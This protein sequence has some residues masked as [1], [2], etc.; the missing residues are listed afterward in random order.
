[1]EGRS[2]SACYLVGVCENEVVALSHGCVFLC[3]VPLQNGACPS[4]E[5]SDYFLSN[6]Y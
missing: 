1:M 2:C 3:V 4:F 5:H 6:A